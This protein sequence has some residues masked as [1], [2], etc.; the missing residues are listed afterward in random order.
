MKPLNELVSKL[1]LLVA[2]LLRTETLSKLS[3]L[4]FL[5]LLTL[6]PDEVVPAF[7]LTA[8]D[9]AT[10]VL[11][12]AAGDSITGPLEVDATFSSLMTVASELVMLLFICIRLVSMGPGESSPTLLL[13]CFLV[14]LV[15]LPDEAVPGLSI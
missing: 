1:F 7:P 5:S 13:S 9:E 15:D 12:G 11:L 3:T 8:D 4:F 14:L 10:G 2:V 6:V